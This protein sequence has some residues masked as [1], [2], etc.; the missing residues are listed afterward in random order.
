MPTSPKKDTKKNRLAKAGTAKPDEAVQSDFAALAVQLSFQSDQISALEERSSDREIAR[1]AL[2][3][4]RKP[5]RYEYNEQT[6]ESHI[7]QIVRLFA[8]AT[9]LS[10]EQSCPAFVSDDPAAAGVRCGFPDEKAHVRDAKSLVIANLHAEVDEQGESVT[11]FFVRRS[12]YF[13]FFGRPGETSTKRRSNSAPHTGGGI[14]VDLQQEQ[15]GTLGGE[16]NASGQERPN[17]REEVMMEQERM[18]PELWERNRLPQE[19]QASVEDRNDVREGD[20]ALQPTQRNQRRGTQVDLERIIADGLARISEYPEDRPQSSPPTAHLERWVAGR[21]G[22]LDSCGS[23][24]RVSGGKVL[25]EDIWI[26]VAS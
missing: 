4:A 11:S 14:H 10:V 18:T 16:R 23:E 24:S 9:P 19:R 22:G 6:L 25:S 20:D 3:N 5:D 12:V 8:T 2:L 7:E 13:A 1:E 17:L 26:V 21:E 15:L